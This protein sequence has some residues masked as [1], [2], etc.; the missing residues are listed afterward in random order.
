MNKMSGDAWAVST[1]IVQGT[2]VQ[3]RATATDA[4]TDMSS[5]RQW[6]P[7]SNTDATLVACGTTTN[8]Q[9]TT[10]DASFS[11]VKGN[12]YWVEAVIKANREIYGVFV[13]FGDCT[14]D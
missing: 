8:P 2:V 11:G 14:T 12:E 13:Y 7:A 9:P 1:R 4:Q 5:C 3:M 6:I 10:F